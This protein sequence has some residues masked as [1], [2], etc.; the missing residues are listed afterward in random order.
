MTSLIKKG[1]GFVFEKVL[2]TSDYSVGI[3][4]AVIRLGETKANEKV[5]RQQRASE[6]QTEEAGT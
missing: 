1:L 5:L 6:I 4:M 2:Q 3:E